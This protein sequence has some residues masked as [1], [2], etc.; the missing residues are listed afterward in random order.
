MR[1]LVVIIAL[2]MPGFAIA[3]NAATLVADQVELNDAQQLIAAGNVEVLF[4]G[5]RLTASQ[6]TYDQ[7]S[8]TLTIIGPIFIRTA[9]N[10]ILTATSA[11]LDPR[12]ENG[13]LQGARIVL[14]RQL[15]LAA[16][17]IDRREGRFSQLYKTAAT[18]CRVC[19]DSTPLWE[20]RAER[21][22]HDAQEKQLYFRNSTFHVRGFPIFWLPYMRLPDPTAERVTG[23]LVPEQRNTSQLGWGIKLPYFITL[24][25]HRDLTV[26]P[27]V[28][29][30]TTT[31]ELRY[32]QAFVNGDLEIDAAASNDTLLDETRSYVFADGSFDLMNDYQLSFDIEA[33]SDPAYLA[34]YGYSSKDRLDSAIEL[35]RVTDDT[36]F[37]TRFTYYQTLRDDE[38]NSSLPPIIADLRYEQSMT[39]EFGGTLT[40]SGSFD[41]AYRY[42][43]TD[44]AEGRDVMRAGLT[45]GWGNNWVLPLGFVIDTQ[46]GARI[47]LYMVDDD[48]EFAQNDLR[49]APAASATLRWPLAMQ[50][51]KEATNLLEPAISVSWG[52]TYGGTP[53][54]EDSTRTELDQ[55]NLFAISRYAGDDAVET[56]AQIAAGLTWTHLRA[57]GFNSMLSFGRVVR[58]NKPTDFTSSSGLEDRTSDWLVAGQIRAP[59][60]FLFEAR[61]LWDDDNGVQVADSRINWQNPAIS[62][63][64]N[65]IWQS[66]DAAA[67]LDEVVS[68]WTLSAEFDLDD[69]WTLDLSGRYNVADDL[70]VRAELGLR[71][72]NEC[73]TVDVS[74]SRRYTSS[75]TVDPTTTFGLS[76]SIGGFS[77]GRAAGGITT[78]CSK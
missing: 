65:Y 40:Y 14:D 46:M 10:T 25:D 7:S 42:S 66:A 67:N 6:I 53:P 3:Q 62:L 30:E 71:W 35:L 44:G 15:Q 72:R 9:D 39:P 18:S 11:T 1:W 78:G 74:A 16:N 33:V 58:Q 49:V 51:V 23:L 60:G 20:I 2:I 55:G 24:G 43:D 56:G 31:L 4:E 17:Q 12:I 8:D 57:D 29:P 21:V 59:G 47:D 61:S 34:N 38:S 73:V 45:G 48:T 68:A 19:G 28:S 37:Q 54:N 26:T 13:I 77:T 70:P 32:R 41:L 69:T 52:Q 27:Y 5:S 63:S 36:L 75:S 64:A 22:V 76:G 50:T